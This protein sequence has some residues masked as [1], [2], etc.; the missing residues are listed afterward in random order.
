MCLSCL[1]RN[2]PLR[3]SISLSLSPSCPVFFQPLH[4]KMQTAE[5][6]DRNIT[7]SVIQQTFTSRQRK[8]TSSLFTVIINSY[9]KFVCPLLIHSS[10]YSLPT[11]II[12]SSPHPIPLLLVAIYLFIVIIIANRPNHYPLSS[13]LYLCS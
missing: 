11:V 9:T 8:V 1:S 4:V 2:S 12:R 3:D 10:V 7:V 13:L 5:I 6:L